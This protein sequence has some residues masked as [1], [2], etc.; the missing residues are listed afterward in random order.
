MNTTIFT[1]MMFFTVLTDYASSGDCRIK[2]SKIDMYNNLGDNKIHFIAKYYGYDGR[3]LQQKFCPDQVPPTWGYHTNVEFVDELGYHV[4]ADKPLP[5]SYVIEANTTQG[6]GSY[7]H[8]VGA[9]RRF[10]ILK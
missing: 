5:G 7:E 1:A 3:L 9:T 4:M 8:F 2:V 10:C 6:R